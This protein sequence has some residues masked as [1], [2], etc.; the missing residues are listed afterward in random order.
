MR[1]W[2]VTIFLVASVLGT[3]LFILGC[4]DSKTISFDGGPETITCN[5]VSCWNPPDQ[6]CL[7]GDDN[8]L[9]IYNSVG[10]CESGDCFYANREEDCQ[11]GI[12]TG[13]YCE[14][15]P[16]QGT[17]CDDSPEPVCANETTII[18]Y[19]PVGY[20]ASS[21]GLPECRYADKAMPCEEGCVDGVCGGD[22]CM[23]KICNR[24]PARYC[25]GDNVVVWE[26]QG[27]CEDGECV[28]S[29]Q[30]VSCGGTCSQGHCVNK[31]PCD[32]V[33]CSSQ[34]ASFCI[35]S[36]TLRVFESQGS[37]AAAACIY[38]YQDLTCDT[39]C[40]D[41][42][43]VGEECA[44]VICDIPF[45]NYC[46]G[47]GELTHWD[48]SDGSC[49]DGFCTYATTLSECSPVCTDGRCP[50]DPCVGVF[51]V[52]PPS[53]YCVDEITAVV[54]QDQ[55]SCEGGTCFYQ[56][57]PVL[58][59]LG[60]ERGACMKEE[61]C[62]A[63]V[64][65]P[66]V[67]Q[68]YLKSENNQ[69]GDYFGYPVAI[70]GDTLVVAASNE[71]I[72]ESGDDDD[73]LQGGVYVFVRS[74]EN[75]SLQERLTAS[76]GAPG[77]LF[78]F[79]VD[80]S[81]DTIVVGAIHESS[82]ATG[83][84]NGSD[85]G[86]DNDNSLDSGAAYVFKRTG[87]DWALEAYLKAPNNDSG[88][89]FGASVAIDGGTIAVGA[90]LERSNDPLDSANNAGTDNGAVYVFVR[91][92]VTWTYQDYLKAPNT[93]DGDTFGSAVDLDGD[94]VVVG[95]YLEDSSTSGIISGDDLSAAN[96]TGSNNGAAYVFK[97]TGSTWDHQA[98]LKAPNNSNEDYFGISVAIAADTVVV[99][100]MLEDSSTNSIVHG[101][102][103]SS[104]NNLEDGSGAVYVFVRSE[105][106]WTHQAYLKAPNSGPFDRFSHVAISGDVVVVGSGLEDGVATD[107]IQCADLFA[108]NNNGLDNGA[109]Y[110]FERSGST[111]VHQAYLKAPNNDSNGDRFGDATAISGDTVVI[112]ASYERST[113][114]AIING[115]DISDTDTNNDGLSVGGYYNGAA[116]VFRH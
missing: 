67:H 51:C 68:A 57:E 50:E 89:L 38:T 59:E 78:G 43:C 93:T 73:R 28:Y 36:D 7:E 103:L 61:R 40:V 90:I 6:T 21:G 55:G 56:V 92:V 14:E 95:V 18:I 75:W 15:S 46:G 65:D 22:P 97:R 72:L 49:E 34:P 80:I 96:D 79:S 30:T 116:Y 19:N 107:V 109:A 45:S 81:G 102:D 114:S 16:C 9:N 105:E 37:C 82:D 8:C 100:A 60:C 113:T 108:T 23:F 84:L 88:D 2:R 10:W 33:N 48:G 13:G 4:G 69:D 41:G 98:Y 111:W 26:P 115:D 112:G 1:V 35:N 62:P 106:T 3:Y 85:P 101:A 53:G 42:Q 70:D 104:T 12:C 66:W 32:V 83:V 58:C 63:D 87:T 11:V 71:N 74:G 20:C 25:D 110:V 5:G 64:P 24:A 31:D 17:T 44:G 94:T 86:P 39:G 52:T 77:D 29:S 47:G 76:N 99:G 91:D 27:T 54:Y